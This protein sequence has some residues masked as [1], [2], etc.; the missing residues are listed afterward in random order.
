VT[1]DGLVG[2]KTCSKINEKY[3]SGITSSF[4]NT[5]ATKM[6][7]IID[8]QSGVLKLNSEG[9]GVKFLQAILKG[10][11]FLGVGSGG[12]DGKY[13]A[14]T[15][16]AVKA[17]QT[18]KNINPD[19]KVGPNETWPAIYE[20]LLQNT[21]ALRATLA[22]YQQNFY[23]L[24][25]P[26]WVSVAASSYSQV[27]LQWKAVQGASS[28]TVYGCLGKNR[29]LSGDDK[30]TIKYTGITDTSYSVKG[31]D[32]S[33]QYYFAVAAVNSTGNE[34]EWSSSKEVTTLSDRYSTIGKKL[35]DL[36][37]KTGQQD[38]VC[39]SVTVDAKQ[40]LMVQ[41]LKKQFNTR[42]EL[43]NSTNDNWVYVVNNWD[44][45]NKINRWYLV[46]DTSIIQKL[47]VIRYAKV[48]RKLNVQNKTTDGWKWC[49]DKHFEL[50]VGWKGMQ[51][52]N[53]WCQEGSAILISGAAK[54]IASGAKMAWRGLL[55]QLTK[56]TKDQILGQFTDPT[57]YLNVCMCTSIDRGYDW[58]AQI[59]TYQNDASISNY[60]QAV[61]YLTLCICME[62]IF[63]LMDLH[64]Q[65]VGLDVDAT[66]SQIVM[67]YV[68]GVGEAFTFGLLKP[69]GRGIDFGDLSNQQKI[70]TAIVKQLKSDSNV[71]NILNAFAGIAEFD[72]CIKK[73]NNL[74]QRGQ[75][76]LVRD[77]NEIYSYQLLKG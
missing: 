60:D 65:I 57:N 3:N 72:Q 68:W 24:D 11:F 34:G 18:Y 49:L 30:W 9:D 44:A 8:S 62:Q 38:L 63:P 75:K 20:L 39:Y 35:F 45:D 13:G 16:T 69:K 12:V 66:T 54:S 47:D 26:V 6:K 14:Y 46:T 70:V 10:Y 53:K 64:L 23:C 29:N 51:E 31:L 55:G 28:Y 74:I 50:V 48:L 22:Q 77:V 76:T 4:R 42:L 5:L 1:V 17:I 32:P 67:D 73:L 43:V 21:A 41:M 56:E 61:E 59:K 15:Y 27:D 52:I 7:A 40:Y 33:T 2:A 25:A 36:Y 58:I 19:G 71:M 37:N